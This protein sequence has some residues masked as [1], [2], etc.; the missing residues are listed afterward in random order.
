MYCGQLTC[1]SLKHF[2]YYRMMLRRKLRVLYVKKVKEWDGHYQQQAE[3]NAIYPKEELQT[4]LNTYKQK[5]QQ[6]LEQK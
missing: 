4:Q 6:E 2:N 1:N 3:Q 5:T